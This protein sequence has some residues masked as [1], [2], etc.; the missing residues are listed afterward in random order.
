[1]IQ[2]ATAHKPPVPIILLRP[3]PAA[4]AG[5][6]TLEW[7][8]ATPRKL[9]TLNPSFL[10]AAAAAAAASARPARRGDVALVLHTSGATSKPKIV[11]LT[12]EN[13]CVGA[14][15]ISSTLRLSP[16]AQDLG[17]NLMP[18]FHI[19]GLSIN[20][21]APLLAGVPLVASPGFGAGVEAIFDWLGA[22]PRPTWYSAV[23]VMHLKILEYAKQYKLEHGEPPPHGLKLVR[24]CSAALVPT[25]GASLERE[26]GVLVL[27]TYAMTECMSICSN[28]RDVKLRRLD[29]VGHS[30]GPE[31][32][33]CRADGSD[34][35]AGEAGEVCVRGA[36]VTKGY[37]FRPAHMSTDPNLEAFHPDTDPGGKWLRTGDKGFVDPATGFLTLVG[38]F[39]EVINRG[40][41]KVSPLEVE[42]ALLGMPQVQELVCFAWPHEELGEVVG[43]AVVRRPGASLTLRHMRDF[44]AGLGGHGGGRKGARLNPKWVPEG[45]LFVDWIP[46]GPTGK[47]NRIGIARALE[48]EGALTPLRA[49]ASMA[50]RLWDAGALSAAKELQRFAKPL[51]R[52][53][54]SADHLLDPP[55]AAAASGQQANS[56][57]LLTLGGLRRRVGGLLEAALREQ[58]AS[59]LLGED[60]AGAVAAGRPLVE[61]GMDSLSFER[62]RGQLSAQLGARLPPTLTLASGASVATI[63]EAL[64][65]N[66]SFSAA[67]RAGPTHGGG[68]GGGFAIEEA[69]EGG[70]EAAGE[71]VDLDEPFELLPMQL[72]YLMGRDQSRPAFLAW[73]VRAIK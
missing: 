39:K 17:L 20:L 41:E 68:G 6:F 37:E 45:V 73:E 24:N 72:A 35:R 22:H 33:V 2:V 54:A 36:C 3:R 38:R 47:P 7:H 57:A 26:L 15:C 29:T 8:P 18:L 27:P 11:P 66:L 1:M 63:V 52:R 42:N 30:G 61:A 53:Q 16:D 13:L 14:Q 60:L 56:G 23:P 70:G 69:T 48:T 43:A 40:G 5:L 46:K 67:L 50:D 59:L 44:C 10:T 12:H 64:T 4:G 31:V 32:R 55:P 71:A 34:C 65:E 49:G 25:L 21:L 28:P 58:V 51:L 9:P 62:L 19:H